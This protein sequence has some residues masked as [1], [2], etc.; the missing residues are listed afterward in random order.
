MSG[1]DELPEVLISDVGTPED[2]RWQRQ[3]Q[4]LVS[5]QPDTQLILMRSLVFIR[6][7]VESVLHRARALETVITDHG[8]PAA[9]QPEDAAGGRLV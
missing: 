3:P 9:D 4:L 6:H 2:E 5:G 1:Q 7:A 8:D